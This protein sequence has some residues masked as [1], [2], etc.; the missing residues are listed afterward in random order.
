MNA[1]Q[2]RVGSMHNVLIQKAR[3]SVPAVMDTPAMASPV[4]ILMSVLTTSAVPMDCAR[5]APAVIHVHVS[6]ASMATALFASM[7]TNVYS[8]IILAVQTLIV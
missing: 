5:I 6:M 3:M 8:E 7:S 1:I 2:V 4:P